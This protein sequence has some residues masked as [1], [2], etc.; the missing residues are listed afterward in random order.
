MLVASGGRDPG[1][2]SGWVTVRSRLI[3]D[4]SLAFCEGLDRSATYPVSTSA[5][6]RRRH[7]S[8]KEKE[9]DWIFGA[10]VVA[11]TSWHQASSWGTADWFVPPSHDLGHSSGTAN[12]CCGEGGVMPIPRYIFCLGVCATMRASWSEQKERVAGEGDTLIFH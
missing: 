12:C 11:P 9:G 4:G 6:K 5:L 7:Q 8:V 1:A 10:D 3:S 2:R